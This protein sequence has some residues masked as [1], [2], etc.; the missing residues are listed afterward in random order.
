MPSGN[1]YGTPPAPSRNPRI[2]FLPAGEPAP[3]DEELRA[4]VVSLRQGFAYLWRAR[5]PRGDRSTPEPWPECWEEHSA[6]A[7]ILRMVKGWHD[8]IAAGRAKGGWLEANDWIECV[9][10]V[11]AESAHKISSAC[12]RGHEADLDLPRAEPAA[13][14]PGAPPPLPHDHPRERPAAGP[15]HADPWAGIIRTS[16]PPVRPSPERDPVER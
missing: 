16:R 15:P 5:V 7:A 4:F 1:E 6:F 10:H 12:R 8:D 11:V 2:T 13:E 9:F 3:I 14:A